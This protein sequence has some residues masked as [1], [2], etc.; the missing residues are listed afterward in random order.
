MDG[1][2]A[3]LAANTS[4]PYQPAFEA[5]IGWDFASGIGTVNASNLVAYFAPFVVSFSPVSLAFPPQALNTGSATLSVTVTDNSAA[6]LNL[7]TVTIGGTNASDFAKSGDT[8][9]GATITPNGTC[10]LGVISTPMSTGP[11]FGTLTITDN[12]NGVTGSV[13]TVVLTSTGINA[14]ASVSPTSLSFGSQVINTTSVAKKV[15]LTS[16]GTTNLSISS[17]DY[18][19][20]RERLRRN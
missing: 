11:L 18:R 14:T 17:I 1:T 19:S 8:C 13:R 10:T 20:E 3:A 12:I 6:N 15:T 4:N 9:T 5:A 2:C 7:S 16:S